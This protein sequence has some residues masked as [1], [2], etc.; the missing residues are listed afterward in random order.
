PDGRW[1]AASDDANRMHLYDAVT[2]RLLRSYDAGRPAAEDGQAFMLGAFSPDSTKLAVV[3]TNAE[4]AEPVR[5][6]DPTTMEPTATKLASPS[7]EPAT[8]VDVQFSADG[9]YLA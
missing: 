7:V 1:I 3:L 6:L 9:R 4:S 8:G 5:L 2:N